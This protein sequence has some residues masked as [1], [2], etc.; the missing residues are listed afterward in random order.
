MEH[1]RLTLTEGYIGIHEMYVSMKAA[2]FSS[3][4][5]LFYLGVWMAASGKMDKE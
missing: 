2:G 4:E 1:E 3:W 5:A